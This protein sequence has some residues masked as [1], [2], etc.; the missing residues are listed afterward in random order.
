MVIICTCSFRRLIAE[1][2]I[3]KILGALSGSGLE[4]VLVDD[5]CR[6]AALEKEILAGWAGNIVVAC[7]PRAVK[8]HFAAA[9]SEAG[10]IFNI[11]TEP[12]EDVIEKMGLV[13]S[14]AD[15]QSLPVPQGDWEPWF[16]VIDRDRC[17]ACRKCM[18]YCLFGVYSS[19]G[20]NVCVTNPAACKNNCPACAR[21][22][23]QKAI[24]FPKYPKSPVNGGLDNEEE[25]AVT[26]DMREL[27]AKGNLY[28]KLVAR[29]RNINRLTDDKD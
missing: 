18:D 29:N 1:D 16:P 5:L 6:I 26:V 9:G 11:R 13:S 19:D 23:P 28:S 25:N 4:Y 21:L 7:Y 22:C 12:V 8:A 14:G 15:T 3:R 10:E 27:Y 2:A 20:K 24:I 17:I